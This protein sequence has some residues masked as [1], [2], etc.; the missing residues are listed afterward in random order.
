MAA[1]RPAMRKVRHR[2][3][4]VTRKEWMHHPGTGQ[5]P[6]RKTARKNLVTSQL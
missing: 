4:M 5:A 2:L 3:L 6:R 1:R